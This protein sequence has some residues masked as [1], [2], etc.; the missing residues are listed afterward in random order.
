MN[1][2]KL[3]LGVGALLLASPPIV[4]ASSLMTIS[5]VPDPFKGWKQIKTFTLTIREVSDERLG[6]LLLADHL[7]SNVYK[8]KLAGQTLVMEIVSA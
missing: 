5:P 6:A 7:P 4:R 2:R 3:L 8:W 1:R